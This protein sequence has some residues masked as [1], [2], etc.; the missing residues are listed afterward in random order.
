MQAERYTYSNEI[1]FTD[2]QLVTR[3]SRKL[4]LPGIED[5]GIPGRNRDSLILAS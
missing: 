4:D 3:D 1:K 5:Q 2:Q